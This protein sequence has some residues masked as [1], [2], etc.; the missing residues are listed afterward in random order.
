MPNEENSDILLESK[1]DESAKTCRP[2]LATAKIQLSMN[3]FKILRSHSVI[4]CYLTLLPCTDRGLVWD[5][6]WSVLSHSYHFVFFKN[7]LDRQHFICRLLFGPGLLVGLT[8]V[9]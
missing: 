5:D 3:V 1:S 8:G 2:Q 7:L 6:M 9:L 4:W